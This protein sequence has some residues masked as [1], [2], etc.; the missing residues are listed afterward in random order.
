MV[1]LFECIFKFILLD[2]VFQGAFTHNTISVVDGCSLLYMVLFLRDKEGYNALMA[3]T[4][5][6]ARS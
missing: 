5:I 1:E 2:D 3:T 4:S 6:V